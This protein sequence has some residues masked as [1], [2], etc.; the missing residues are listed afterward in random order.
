MKKLTSMVCGALALGNIGCSSIY[1]YSGKIGKDKALF[2]FSIDIPSGRNKLIII[3]PDGRGIEYIDSSGNDLKLESV[4]II[5]NGIT[6]KYF[7]DNEVGKP[8]VEKAQ[9]QFD[10]Y[11]KKI[12]EIKIQ[13]GLNDL[14]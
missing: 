7:I 2:K 14:D 8:V 3:K 1:E 5:K 9:E 12:K 13:Q 10:A 4:E 11:L 6:K